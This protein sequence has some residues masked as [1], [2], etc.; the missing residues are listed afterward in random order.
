MERVS[1]TISNTVMV[2]EE[3]V[4]EADY[5]SS[6]ILTVWEFRHPITFTVCE[7]EN[8]IVKFAYRPGEHLERAKPQLDSDFHFDRT[9]FTRFTIDRAEG[10]WEGVRL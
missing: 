4:K 8:D 1:R 9:S 2:G 7:S 10:E 3:V 5:G 6:N